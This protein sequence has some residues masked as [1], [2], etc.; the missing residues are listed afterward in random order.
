MANE[1]KPKKA[2]KEPAATETEGILATTAKAI[3]KAAGKIAS[4][5]GVAPEPVP[6]RPQTK[7]TKPEKLQKKNKPRLPRRQKKAQKKAAM[8]NQAK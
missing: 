2:D 8:A 4:L 5:T 3:G 6:A 7:S 1:K